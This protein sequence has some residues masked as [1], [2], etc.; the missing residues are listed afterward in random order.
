M[1]TQSWRAACALFLVAATSAVAA[2]MP[3]PVASGSPVTLR[4]AIEQALAQSPELGGFSHRRRAQ[5][6]RVGVAGLSPP[7]ELRTELENFGGTGAMEGLDST[8][9]TFALSRVIEL[10]S[11]RALREGAARASRDDLDVERQ[12]A[13][14]D[15]IAEVTRR[16]IHVASDQEQLALTHRATALSTSSLEAVQRRVE[17]GRAPD[18]ELHRAN[19]AVARARIEE[20][21]A[22]HEL[23]TS[24]RKLAAMWGAT[25]AT[26]GEVAGDLYQYPQLP[27]FEVLVTRLEAN[28]DFLRFASELR[29]RDAEV[30]VAQARARPDLTVTAGVRRLEASDD[31]AFVVGLSVPLFTRA[32]ARGAID[33]ASALRDQTAAEQEARR[34]KVNAQ[35]FEIYQEL[36]HSITEATMLRDVVLPQT[37]A[38]LANTQVAFDRGRY[39]YL[40]WTDAQR[41]LI[42]AQRDRITASANAHLFLAEIERLTNAPVSA[43]P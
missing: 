17:A 43:A 5:D 41:E 23:L 12:A 1:F 32:R 29:V 30:R 20:E 18:A 10:G 14:L 8:E 19:I 27:E 25:E 11:K 4:V 7:L 40:E 35:L 21:H 26:F 6:A 38:A 13:Q 42:A 34:V 24:R 16:F 2:Q 31:Q 28:P 9:A 39:S 37:E 22:E 33:E 3:S 36:R 15:V